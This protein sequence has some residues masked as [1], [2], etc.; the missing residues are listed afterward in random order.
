[1]SYLRAAQI[2][3]LVASTLPQ[4]DATQRLGEAIS[5]IAVAEAR[6]LSP[7]GQQAS[8]ALHAMLTRLEG[9]RTGDRSAAFGAAQ[10]AF[11]TTIEI[12]SA[13]GY[14][15]RREVGAL[16][17]AT[18]QRTWI[19]ISTSAA[20]AVIIIVLL[21]RS[22]LPQLR[23]AVAIA[24]SI[25]AGRLD[26]P[27]AITGRSETAL[28][29]R[30]LA[31]MQAAIAASQA[32]NGALLQQQQAEHAAQ[33]RHQG[34][35]DAV[36]LC[37]ASSIGG[38]F[39]LVSSASVG[40]AATADGLVGDAAALLRSELDVNGQV[41]QVVA[42]IGNASQSSRALSEAIFGIRTET[43][44]TEQRA[45][46]TLEE[47]EA[48]TTRMQSLG[49]AADE[50]T[51]VAG[52][53]G[54]LA[55]QTKLLALNASIEAARAGGAGLGFAVVATE[56]KR[57]AERSAQAAQIVG[58]HI[59]SVQTAAQGTRTSIAA[60]AAS[61][62]D[63][64]RLS[65]SIAQAVATQETASVAM[66]TTIADILTNAHSVRQSLGTIGSLTR[67]G[68]GNLRGIAEAA[69]TLARSATGLGGDVSAYLEMV[70]DIKQGDLAGG[71]PIRAPAALVLN[72][73]SHAGEAI[74]RSEFA[75]CFAPAVPAS[76]GVAG[77][78]H[79][80]GAVGIPVRVA[81]DGEACTHLQPPLAPAERARMRTVL[82]NFVLA[83]RHGRRPVRVAA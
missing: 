32:E 5:N 52:M 33:A 22:I 76:V 60:I 66:R 18:E 14:H 26:T 41:E 20:A 57:L 29:L 83:Q 27:I 75:L 3:L 10:T 61:T 7:S 77:T 74:C 35:L 63:V 12:F 40:M 24:Q 13:D 50:I 82:E 68:A 79:V 36:G 46:M 59:A 39:H 15:L 47:A 55:A 65:A 45:R 1:M 43:A 4:A 2:D 78:L 72:G 25:A 8:G 42:R 23:E 6:A 48:A 37:F 31:S 17:V 69:Q 21:S 64:H 19:M 49:R 34:E 71:E 9:D 62:E 53:I 30:A 16:L 44:Q 81:H 58:G 73:I 54:E 67:T 28:L 38:V 80:D 56:V 70:R 51:A 11:A